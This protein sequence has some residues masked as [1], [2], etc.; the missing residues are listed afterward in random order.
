MARHSSIE[1]KLTANIQVDPETG[2]WLWQL[3]TDP[4]GYGQISFGG[5]ILRA[6]RAAYETWVGPIPD[7]LVIDHVHE[8]GC[9]HRHCVN[10]AHLE[11]VTRT[12]NA[13]RGMSPAQI[14]W[15]TGACQRGHRIEGENARPTSAGH[16]QCRAC[17]DA[18]RERR[19][20]EYQARPT[21][22]PL[23]PP[24]VATPD[25]RTEYADYIER[26]VAEAPPLTSEQV[27]R[28]TTLLNS[29]AA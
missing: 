13:R 11:P 22:P 26:V 5:R 8:R 4:S 10:P 9:R 21:A 2:C 25:P 27:A 29:A 23:V 28:I 6:H 12:E 20:T 24:P 7:G 3:S 16:F 15:R 1:E 14:T 18:A 17:Y 19:R